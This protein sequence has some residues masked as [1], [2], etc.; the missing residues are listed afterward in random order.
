[1]R[2]GI[3]GTRTTTSIPGFTRWPLAAVRRAESARTRAVD[4]NSHPS[5]GA[6]QSD[7]RFSGVARTGLLRSPT[8]WPGAKL[9]RRSLHRKWFWAVRL[10][11][12]GFQRPA[13]NS[14]PK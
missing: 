1:M 5:R 10:Q 11:T 3:S 13:R 6:A 8:H 14:Y 12:R 9:P 2:S 4:G 7:Y